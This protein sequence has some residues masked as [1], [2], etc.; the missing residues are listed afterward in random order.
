MA[1]HPIRETLNGIHCTSD[2][3]WLITTPLGEFALTDYNWEITGFSP[4]LHSIDPFIFYY[5]G[6]ALYVVETYARNRG[7][8]IVQAFDQDENAEDE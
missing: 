5:G 6:N 7:W 8:D 2:R 3:L 1:L 4:E